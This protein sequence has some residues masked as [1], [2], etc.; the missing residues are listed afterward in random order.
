ME[1]M[2]LHLPGSSFV[3]P[4]TPLR[5]ALT[6]EA[7]RQVTA[8]TAL[9]DDYTPVGEMI[10]ERAIVNGCVALLATGGSTNHT[11][12]LVAIAHAAGI[13]LTWNDI[14][15]LS[16]VVPLLARIYP[17]G[18]AD[19]NHF[20]AAGGLAFIIS[21]PARRR[22][23]ARGRTDR[24][25]TRT[26]AATPQEPKLDGDGVMWLDGTTTQPR[27]LGAA[28]GRRPVRRRRRPENPGRQS[29]FGA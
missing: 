22:P 28:P 27:H 24:R 17:N 13:T 18:S 2:G 26:C 19:V 1:V 20:H 5:T 23:A 29:R 11:M 7:G 25:R 21:H 10:D 15:E 12:H 14:S 9:G 4:D 8:L 3:N 16:A 6:A